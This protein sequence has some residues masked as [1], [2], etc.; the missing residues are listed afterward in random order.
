MSMYSAV[1]FI[2]VLTEGWNHADGS[3]E[4]AS[5]R[6]RRRRRHRLLFCFVLQLAILSV[7]ESWDVRLSNIR[8]DSK[9]VRVAVS[10][11]THA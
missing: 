9:I 11:S 3:Q 6:R 5:S 2:I 1:V 10:R 4:A 7:V 8:S